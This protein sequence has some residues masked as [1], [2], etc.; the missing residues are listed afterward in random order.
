MM[1]DF[2]RPNHSDFLTNSEL[3]EKK[4]SGIRFN[5][6][7]HYQELWIEGEKRFE[8]SY[9]ELQINPNIWDEKYEEAF[10]LYNVES[11]HIGGN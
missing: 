3:K 11:V 2:K 6:I 8:V 10:K 4:F 9:A 7:S 1:E 5:S